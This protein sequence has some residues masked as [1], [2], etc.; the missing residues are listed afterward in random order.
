MKEKEYNVRV[1]ALCDFVKQSDLEDLRE[2]IRSR[3][4]SNPFVF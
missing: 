3:G 2:D 1:K 4:C